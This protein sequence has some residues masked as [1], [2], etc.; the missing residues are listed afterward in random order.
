M[1]S[2]CRRPTS[3]LTHLP[4]HPVPCCSSG[5]S[6]TYRYVTADEAARLS[7]EQCAFLERK[8]AGN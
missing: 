7:P 8:R 5:A 2:A 1:P 6:G 3:L 4:A